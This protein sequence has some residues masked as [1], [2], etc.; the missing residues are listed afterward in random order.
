MSSSFPPPTL[1]F[2]HPNLRVTSAGVVIIARWLAAPAA[3]EMR[4]MRQAIRP[5]VARHPSFCSLN[6]IDIEHAST[7]PE[8]A[9]LEVALTQKEFASRQRGLANV[10]EGQGF[11]AAAIRSVA[12]GLALLS[13]VQF[14]QKVFDGV[15]PAARWLASLFPV[16]AVNVGA[17]VHAAAWLRVQGD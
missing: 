5:F 16:G 8:D 15:D 4:Q 10:I 11:Y 17:V 1:A 3:T 12:S 14:D 2:E 6:I 13:R 7:M 9:R